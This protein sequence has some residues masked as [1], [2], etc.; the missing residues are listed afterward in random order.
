MVKI[1]VWG[2]GS[3]VSSS[4]VERRGLLSQEDDVVGLTLRCTWFR[5]HRCRLWSAK[6]PADF[7][8]AKPSVS[9]EGVRG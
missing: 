6:S 4:P 5:L 7:S 3:G 8:R 1:K 2:S 9:A